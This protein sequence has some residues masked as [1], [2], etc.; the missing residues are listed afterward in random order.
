MTEEEKK[1]N[2]MGIYDFALLVNIITTISMQ[3]YREFKANNPEPMTKEQ[4][5]ELQLPLVE[6]RKAAVKSAL[7]A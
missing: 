6:M 7:E 4:W 5:L 1:A 3:I 2:A